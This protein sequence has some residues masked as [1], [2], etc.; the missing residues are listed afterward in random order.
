MA[1]CAGTLRSYLTLHDA[2]PAEPLV[3]MVPISVRRN[4]EEDSSATGSRPSLASWRPMR[5]TR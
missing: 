5:P 1:L 3:A 4:D 2:L